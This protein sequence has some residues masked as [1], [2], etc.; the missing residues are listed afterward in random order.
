MFN[1]YGMLE[2]IRFE[3]QCQAAKNH[4]NFINKKCKRNRVKKGKRKR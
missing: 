4:T 2:E 1:V 3:K